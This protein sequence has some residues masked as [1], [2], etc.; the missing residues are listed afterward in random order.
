MAITQFIGAS[1]AGLSRTLEQ[2]YRSTPGAVMLTAD[3]R[4]H[5][6]YLRATVA[7]ELVFGLEQRGVP[8]DK[9]RAELARMARALDL[10]SLL[11]RSP[12]ELSGGQTR[13]LAIGTVAILGAPTLLLDEPFAGLDSASRDLLRRLLLDYP[14]DVVLAGHRNYLDDVP[15]T[16][17]GEHQVL[18]LPAR[19]SPQQGHREFS[20]IVGHRGQAKRRWWQFKEPA[21]QFT[22]GPIDCAVP[23]GGVL[24]MQGKNGAGK[25]TL[26]RAMAN[27]PGVSLMLQD[28]H[29]QVIDA[30]VADMVPGSTDTTHPLDLSQ[31]DLRLVQCDSA[32]STKPQVLLADEP[33]VGLDVIGRSQLHQKFADYLSSGG[34]LVLSCHDDQFV[35]EV[36][37]YATVESLDISAVFSAR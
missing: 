7:E 25:S 5:I 21:A 15:T 19:V 31:K 22:I 23:V 37:S 27:D 11:D 24:W 26:L 20:G 16:Y 12:T 33:D 29:D 3:P 17:L 36:L 34:A 14:G 1:G 18:Q 4:A 30:T 10:E 13:R 35:Q 32:L 6:T 8:V 2:L 9:M 28:P